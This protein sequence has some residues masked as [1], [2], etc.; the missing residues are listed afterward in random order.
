MA[1]GGTVSGLSCEPILRELG[2]GGPGRLVIAHLGNGAS[3]TAV[4]DGR[5]ID[6]SMDLT[7]SGS[8]TMA[9]RTGDIEPGVLLFLLREKGLTVEALATTIDHASGMTGIRRVW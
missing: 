9:T 8:V 7:P 2:T 5:S 1:F 4:R 6:T 3:I